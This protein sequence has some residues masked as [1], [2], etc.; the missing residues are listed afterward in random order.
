LSWYDHASRW[1]VELAQGG[2]SSWPRTTVGDTSPPVKRAGTT[3]VSDVSQTDTSLSFHVSKVGVPVLVK[4]SY[5]PNW[6]T[7]GADGP[8]RVTPNL[9][10]VVPTSHDVTLSYGRSAADDLGQG[11]TL[12][13]LVVLV[14]LFVVPALRRW[15]SGARDE[16]D[17][18]ETV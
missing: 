18:T 2:P 1:N 8:Y 9:M 4:V 5:F 17:R 16:T 11:L 15:W 10:V 7:S 6:H 3:R 12:L 13:G 14:L